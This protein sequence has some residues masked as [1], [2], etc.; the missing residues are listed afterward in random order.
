MTK[1]FKPRGMGAKDPLK[2]AALLLQ[3][4]LEKEPAVITIGMANRGLIV[5]TREK[6]FT[7]DFDEFRRFPVQ[8]SYIGEIRAQP[9]TP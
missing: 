7:L 8:V 6:D 4:R 5:Y 3:K 1:D 9:F 2:Y